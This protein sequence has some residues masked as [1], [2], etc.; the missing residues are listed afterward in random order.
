M[1]RVRLYQHERGWS[2]AVGFLDFFDKGEAPSPRVEGDL[3]PG[4]IA[5]AEQRRILSDFSHRKVA[6][7]VGSYEWRVEYA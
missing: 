4:L 7:I 3:P 2:R 1:V 6:G 5:P